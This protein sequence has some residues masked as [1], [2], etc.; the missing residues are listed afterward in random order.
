MST[1]A[2]LWGCISFW[3]EIWPLYSFQRPKGHFE[4][5]DYFEHNHNS[6]SQASWIKIRIPFFC[7]LHTAS[8]KNRGEDN[9]DLLFEPTKSNEMSTIRLQFGFLND[10][11]WLNPALFPFYSDTYFFGFFWIFWIFFFGFLVRS[12]QPCRHGQKGAEAL[13]AVKLCPGRTPV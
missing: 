7:Q 6:Q 2:I 3:T 12:L 4:H 9:L 10:E 13:S 11:L 1:S 8:E 5:G